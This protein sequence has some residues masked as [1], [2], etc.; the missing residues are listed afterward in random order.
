MATY[1]RI[2]MYIDVYM[3]VGAFSYTPTCTDI[4]WLSP[5][6]DLLSLRRR[7]S[8][9]RQA[10]L[11]I[12]S[13]TSLPLYISFSSSWSF[14]NPLIA[15]LSRESS[16]VRSSLSASTPV[17]VCVCASSLHEAERV[18]TISDR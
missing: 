1:I 4:V 8:A 9:G 15:S 17:C 18:S 2:H 7:S 10:S 14:L 11:M 16:L 3:F 12:H 5:F 6:L 13:Q